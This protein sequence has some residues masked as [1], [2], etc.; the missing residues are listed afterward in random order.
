[1]HTVRA[2]AHDLARLGDVCI[3]MGSPFFGGL[4]ERAVACYDTDPVLRDLLDRHAHRSRIG[5]RLGGAAHFRALRGL[6]PQI[7]AHYPSTGGDGDVESAWRAVLADIHAHVRAYDELFERPVQTNEVARALPVLGAML[8]LVFATQLPLRVFEIGSSAG[9]ILNFDRYRYA[10]EGWTWGDPA[11][12]VLLRNRTAWGAPAYPDAPLRVIERR[13]CDLHPLHASDDDDTDTLLCFVWPDQ[14]ERFERLRAAIEVAR[15]HP[16]DIA[17]G[18]GIAWARSTALPQ[19]RAA[20]V[21]MHTVIT[22]HMTAGVRASLRD[23]IDALAAQATPSAPFAWIRM[24]PGESGYDTLLTQW[25]AE[26]QTVIARSDG[27]AQN[28]RWAA[29]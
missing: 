10:G 16:P 3:Q 6:A 9:L 4:L 18:D 14:R 13:G 7:A 1:M 12:P 22:E 29:P 25:P 27:H 11:S 5:L 21:V 24:E 2:A 26:V 23:A 20:T 15:A 28:L 8:A 17:S 19:E